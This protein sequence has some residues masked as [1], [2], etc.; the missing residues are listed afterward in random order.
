MTYTKEEVVELC[1]KA[2]NQGECGEGCSCSW[3]SF[4]EWLDE[5][6]ATDTLILDGR[7]Q[8]NNQ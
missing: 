8:N 3:M 7:R 5:N 6:I 1:R 2:F 4:D